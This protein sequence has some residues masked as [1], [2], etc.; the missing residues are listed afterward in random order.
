MTALASWIYFQPEESTVTENHAASPKDQAKGVEPITRLKIVEPHSGGKLKDDLSAKL[1][2]LT[3]TLAEQEKQMAEGKVTAASLRRDVALLQSKMAE[4]QKLHESSLALLKQE[5]EKARKAWEAER[6]TAEAKWRTALEKG[7]TEARFTPAKPAAPAKP[8][9]FKKMVGEERA[10][11]VRVD[12]ADGNYLQTALNKD[13]AIKLVG[14]AR[15]LRVEAINESAYLD[16]TGLIVEDIEIPGGIH[17][18][19]RVRLRQ[20]KGK[21]TVGDITGSPVVDISGT[22]VRVIIGNVQGDARLAIRSK[23]LEF[24]GVINGS[25]QV[26]ATITTGGRLELKQLLGASRLTW[27]REHQGEPYPHVQVSDIAPGAVLQQ[28][29]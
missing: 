25:P 1:T 11:T 7:V 24:H 20:D 10:K 9:D 8:A 28:T 3:T 12:K 21:V 29:K 18:M 23:R 4:Q 17:G 13:Q 16:T 5:G 27:S 26:F 22:H 14:R 6:Q 2:K 19:A 15:K